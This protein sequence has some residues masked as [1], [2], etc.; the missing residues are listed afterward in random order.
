[1]PPAAHLDNMRFEAIVF[2]RSILRIHPMVVQSP[3]S[4]SL[5]RT[6]QR[7]LFPEHALTVVRISLHLKDCSFINRFGN[8]ARAELRTN[9]LFVSSVTTLENSNST[10][11]ETKNNKHSESVSLSL[12]KA[13]D[14][15]CAKRLIVTAQSVSCHACGDGLV[16]GPWSNTEPILPRS[17]WSAKVLTTCSKRVPLG[18][19]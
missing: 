15:H 10:Y 3:E 9:A 19:Y 12:R 14:C 17:A 13:S 6:L 16:P 7:T 4:R 2:Q 1:M 11:L 8:S 18:V 5:K